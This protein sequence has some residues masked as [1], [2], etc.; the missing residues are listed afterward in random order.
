MLLPRAYAADCLQLVGHEIDHND[1][2]ET[3]GLPFELAGTAVSP[4]KGSANAETS[5]LRFYKP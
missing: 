3:R 5:S 1:E 4:T 2:L